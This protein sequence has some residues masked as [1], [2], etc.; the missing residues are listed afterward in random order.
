MA[1]GYEQVRSIAAD[2]AG[3][4]EAALRV[5][6][7]LPE[8]GVC[9][10]NRSSETASESCCGNSAGGQADAGY[11]TAT[12]KAKEAACCACGEFPAFDQSGGAPLLR[13]LDIENVQDGAHGSS[14][15]GAL[16]NRFCQHSFHLTKI[17]DL[18]ANIV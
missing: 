4:S 2:I 17:G 8:T 9:S 7:E 15:A 1:T 14:G 16:R 5:E 13:A 18:G 10:L 12:E 3:D 11:C 6:L